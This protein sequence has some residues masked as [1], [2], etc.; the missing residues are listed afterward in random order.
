MVEGVDEEQ[1]KKLFRRIK[2]ENRRE[3][4]D[5]ELAKKIWEEEKIAMEKGK[6]KVSD[7]ANDSERGLPLKKRRTSGEYNSQFAA[8]AADDIITQD[9][10][11]FSQCNDDDEDDASTRLQSQG[12]REAPNNTVQIS[13]GATTAAED[14]DYK[15]TQST[16]TEFFKRNANLLLKMNTDNSTLLCCLF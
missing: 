6:K 9:G 8:H 11:V 2:A 3:K 7:C 1:Q 13:L 15:V 10:L 5:F 4:I 16:S 12:K 14:E